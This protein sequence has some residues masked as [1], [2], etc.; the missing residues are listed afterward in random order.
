MDWTVV[1]SNPGGSEFF[2]PTC[3]DWPCGHRFSFAIGSSLFP[4]G[5]A[6]RTWC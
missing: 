4:G 3:P 6:A 2:F 1:G 5:K